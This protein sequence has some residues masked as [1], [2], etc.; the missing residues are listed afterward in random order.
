MER[1]LKCLKGA[2]LWLAMYGVTLTV[3][4]IES[5]HW[6][7]AAKVALLTATVK[8]LVA[9]IHKFC[10]NEFDRPKMCRCGGIIGK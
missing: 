1:I 10:W 2:S 5:G 8:T 3:L 4:V 9:V 7:W 6:G